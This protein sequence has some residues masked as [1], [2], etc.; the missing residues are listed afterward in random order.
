[1]KKYLA[2]L[3]LSAIAG[4]VCSQTNIYVRQKKASEMTSVVPFVSRITYAGSQA[5]LWSGQRELQVLDASDIASMGMQEHDTLRT[6]LIPTQYRRD[7]DFDIAFSDTDHQWTAEPEV[8]DTTLST[9]DDF[10]N[11]STWDRHVHIFYDGTTAIATGVPEGV[12]IDTDGCHVTVHSA[13]SG[14]RYTLKGHAADGSFKLYSE[15]KSLVVLDGIELTNPS[16]PALNSQSKKRL[17]VHTAPNTVNTLTDG[18]TYKKVSGE[19]QRGCIFAEGRLCLSGEG[20]LYVNGHKKGAIAS[21]DK[22]HITSGYIRANAYAQK[23]RA[24]HAK[25]LFLMGGGSVQALGMGD[26]SKGISSDSLITVSGGLVKVI[27]TGNAIYEE[28]KEDYTSSCGIKSEYDMAL[29]GGE[30]YVM[31]TGTGGKGISAG[32]TY[33]EKNGKEV[34]AGELKIDGSRIWVRT[35]GA[36]IPE[37]KT[38][39]IHGNKEGAA[40]SPKGIKSAG[41]ITIDDG[42]IYVRCCGGNAAE[43][44]E[45]KKVIT[46]NGGKIRS[47]C[48]DDGMNAEGAYIKGGDV[49]LCSTT[50]DGFDVSFLG[51]TGGRLYT[52]G[53][54]VDQMGMDTDG[55]TFYIS[56]GHCTAIGANNCFPFGNANTQPSVIIYLQHNVSHLQ[57]TDTDGNVV[58]DIEVPNYYIG[59]VNADGKLGKNI[60]ILA[61]GET[62]QMGKAYRVYSY[63]HNLNDTPVLEYEFTTNS[64]FTKLGEFNKY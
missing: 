23:G 13:I 51:L 47:Y 60:A 10:V 14:V 20:E 56:Q 33:T 30:I 64:T 25:E 9:Y 7:F 43:G 63:A 12:T 16:G 62:L 55:K 24:I 41:K 22:I 11:H 1:M 31:S 32:N 44:I 35:S 50:N 18:D 19:D 59:S 57:I 39:D 52:I 49:F 17:F 21:D 6:S 48:V 34:F 45:S 58:Q 54:P 4:N 15:K 61:G 5:T 37:V 46:I 29:H 3:T 8:T 53:A 38:E 28:E 2:L 40:A 27:T 42:E 36:R 26:A